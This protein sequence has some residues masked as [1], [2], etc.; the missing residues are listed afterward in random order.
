MT[1]ATPWAR[2]ANRIEAELLAMADESPANWPE[3]EPLISATAASPYPLDALPSPIR[4]AV[5]EV[6]AFCQT[7]VSL[8]ASSALSAISLA[9]QGLASVRRAEGLEGPA[10]LYL[11]T[12][13]ESGERKTTVDDKFFAPIREFE[14]DEAERV[15]P[16]FAEYAA[17]V[18][19]WEAKVKGVET[20]LQ[21]A[22]KRGQPIAADEEQLRTLELSKPIAP[23]YPR[24]LYTDAT[25]EALSKGLSGYPSAGVFSAEGGAVLG[26]CG[27]SRDS[28]MRT[29][30]LYNAAWDGRLPPSDRITRE[31]SGSRSV[32]LTCG[33]AAQ[34]ETARAFVDGSRGLARG[35]GYLA[36]YL[37]AWPESTQGTRFFKEPPQGWPCLARF[38]DRERDLLSHRL[39]IDEGGLN[40]AA[41]DFTSA[42]KREWVAF[43]DD[44][45]RMLGPFGEMA[46]VR[47]FASK[48]ADNAA[49]LAALFHV[50]RHGPEGE[51]GAAEIGAAARIV[52]WHS[53]EA[54]RFVGELALPRATANASA[55]DAWL[56]ERCRQ[57]GC[58]IVPRRDVQRLG[59]GAVREPAALA[60]ALET[61]TA[62]NRIRE[63]SDGQRLI[64]VNPA[65]L[66]V[67]T[68]AAVAVPK[69]E[70]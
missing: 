59:P 15:R 42:A 55:L 17:E 13:A 32:R 27:M 69:G 65:L 52:A 5:D 56:V 49:R 36:R 51:I 29:L 12:I 57:S 26:G 28:Q 19:T 3:P 44:V 45:E 48:A 64:E 40:P 34:P 8:A 22:T 21:Q 24:M 2:D 66:S 63:T 23:T 18:R 67:A 25:P 1:P 39:E 4:E 7:P 50:F 41:L 33:I 61:L 11:L 68:V 9:G 37:F 38:H 10:S 20:R 47:D 31:A 14:S 35:S 58:A 46:T 70:Q 43:H 62:A 6:N 30:A 54:L 60:E 16:A 53:L